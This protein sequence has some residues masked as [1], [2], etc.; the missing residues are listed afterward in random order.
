MYLKI[1]HAEYWVEQYGEGEPVLFLHGFT[2]SSLTW[3]AL[4][5]FFPNNRMILI[6][7]P[8]HGKTKAETLTSMKDCC[9]AISA[10]LSQLEIRKVHIVGYSMGGRTALTFAHLYP[11]FV[12]SL[13]LESASP[14]IMNK[15]ERE[16]RKKGDVALVSF[17]RTNPLEA[18]VDK[19]ENLPLFAS[20][21][22]MVKEKQAAVRQ[23]RLAQSAEGLAH[24]LTTMGTGVMPSLW[25]QL[26][27]LECSVLLVVGEK[28]DKFVLLNRKMESL[29]SNCT[30][31]MIEDAGHAIH[32]E[33]TQIFGTIVEE[34]I[35]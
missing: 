15:E 6:D 1:R 33:Q 8:G 34:F 28:D 32:V 22:S 19:W 2:G 5:S 10:I 30:F 27:R 29:I 18:F 17:L 23:E 16:E 21:K 20:Q 26:H 24:S 25:E 11:S 7:L 4:R 12:K 9:D 3:H 35:N 31:K 13:V 14:G